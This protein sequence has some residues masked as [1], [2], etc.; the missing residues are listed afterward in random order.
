MLLRNNAK[1]KIFPFPEFKIKD[2]G[3]YFSSNKRH[4][5]YIH[6]AKFMQ[7]GTNV[8]LR[9]GK[10]YITIQNIDRIFVKDNYLYFT[11]LGEVKILCNMSRVKKYFN[12]YIKSP[13]IDVINM[14]KNAK[15]SMINHLFNINECDELKQYLKLVKQ[16][17]N[18]KLL[19][20]KLVVGKN[21][22]NIR[23]TLYYKIHKKIKKLNVI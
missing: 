1:L 20:D 10:I 3:I 7:V 5:I 17:L 4:K 15:N 2:S 13:Q 11:A 9:Q 18:I 12:I 19:S 8:Y 22:Y 16:L 23:Y 14:Q 6:N 21:R